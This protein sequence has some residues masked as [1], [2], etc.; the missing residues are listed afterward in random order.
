M[1]HYFLTWERTAMKTSKDEALARATEQY[2]ARALSEFERRLFQHFDLTGL[3]P[4]LDGETLTVSFPT[5]D[6]PVLSPALHQHLQ[7]MGLSNEAIEQVSERG[8]R[9]VNQA[10]V[11][12]ILASRIR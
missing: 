5:V 9:A 2:A 10:I 6:G 8:F 7:T 4:N 1:A 3:A 12:E 11:I